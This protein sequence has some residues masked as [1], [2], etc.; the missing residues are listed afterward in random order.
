MKRLDELGISPAP[1]K[2]ETNDQSEFIGILNG[3]GFYVAKFAYDIR[4]SD[5]RLFGAAPKMYKALY[6][7]LPIARNRMPSQPTLEEIEVLQNA[8]A[9]LA[10]AAGESEVKS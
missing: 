6:D 10:E 2:C 3:R 7:I 5:A 1:W 4:P 8:E 9:V